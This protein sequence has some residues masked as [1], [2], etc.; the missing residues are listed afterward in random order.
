MSRLRFILVAGVAALVAAGGSSAATPKLVG[1]VGPNASFKI[2]LTKG[3]KKVTKIKHGTYLIVISDTA[4]IHDFHLKGP[5]VDKKTSVAGK[6]TKTWKVTLKK[7]KYTY[8]CDPHAAAM[9]GTFT[10]T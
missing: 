1:H 7:G 3:G 6:G 2:S 9:R 10:V 8:V 5:G 4:S